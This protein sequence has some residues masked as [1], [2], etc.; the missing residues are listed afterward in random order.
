VAAQDQLRLAVHLSG[1]PQVGFGQILPLRLYYL[2]TFVL[3]L[4]AQFSRLYSTAMPDRQMRRPLTCLLT[5]SDCNAQTQKIVPYVRG[6]TDRYFASALRSPLR[7][8]SG[9]MPQ[10]NSFESTLPPSARRRCRKCGLPMFLVLIEP[11]EDVDRECRAFECS[12]CGY[13]ET[14]SVKFR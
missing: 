6:R 13:E 8:G 12:S 7:H 9:A 1:Q 2:N 11:T 3:R 14:V 4:R 10:P 5:Y